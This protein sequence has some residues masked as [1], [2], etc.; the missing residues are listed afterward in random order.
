ML[1]RR[2]GDRRSALIWGKDAGFSSSLSSLGVSG[3]KMFDTGN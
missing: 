1:G 2:M 3:R